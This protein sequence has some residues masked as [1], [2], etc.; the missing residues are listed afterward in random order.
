MFPKSSFYKLIVFS[1]FFSSQDPQSGA[2]GV[3][4]ER[5]A[6]GV[7]LQRAQDVHA[8]LRHDHVALPHA[9]HPLQ[10]RLRSRHHSLPRRPVDCRSLCRVRLL[11]CFVAW[12][13]LVCLGA[14][15]HEGLNLAA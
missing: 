3:P 9:R 7:P 6:L 11:F 1:I 4:G 14:W 8:A 5:A 10:A 12:I 2:T 13:W 15:V